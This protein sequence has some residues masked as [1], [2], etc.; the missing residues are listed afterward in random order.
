MS[1]D[2]SLE[3]AMLAY[4]ENVLKFGSLLMEFLTSQ[5]AQAASSVV[6]CIAHKA[7]LEASPSRQLSVDAVCIILRCLINSVRRSHANQGK[8]FGEDVQDV[9]KVFG[10]LDPRISDFAPSSDTGNA[11]VGVGNEIPTVAPSNQSD[12]ASTVAVMLLLTTPGS[13]GASTAFLPSIEK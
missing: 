4:Q 2:F 8:E 11:K 9:Y 6:V 12:A 3:L 1:V 13:S 5:G 7:L 10:R